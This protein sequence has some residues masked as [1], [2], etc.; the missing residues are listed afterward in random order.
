MKDYYCEDC[1]HEQG[2]AL[3]VYKHC[4]TDVA[5]AGGCSRGKFLRALVSLVSAA[6]ADMG[7]GHAR[8]AHQVP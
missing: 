2:L 4:L 1:P 5:H 8:G 3:Q 6:G 7:G